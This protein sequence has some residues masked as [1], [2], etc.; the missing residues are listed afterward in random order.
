MTAT[1][2]PSHP[3]V[4]AEALARR[5]V[6]IHR[7]RI[8]EEEVEAKPRRRDPEVDALVRRVLEVHAAVKGEAE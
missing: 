4:S 6:S 5:V 7:Q 2:T 8:G 1:A 3:G